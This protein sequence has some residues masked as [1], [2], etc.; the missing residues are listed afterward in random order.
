MFIAWLAGTPI[1]VCHS[2]NSKSQYEEQSGRHK[3]VAVYRAIMRKLLWTFS[4]FRC[5]CSAV[6]MDYLYQNKW[7]SDPHS[8]VVYNGIDLTQ[9]SP[10]NVDSVTSSAREKTLI[11]VGRFELQKNPHFIVKVM[12]ALCDIDSEYTLDWI[13]TG[14]MEAEIRAEIRQLGLEKNIKLL[15]KR[16]DVPDLLKQASGFLLPSLFE[17]L[18]IALIEAQAAGLTCVVSD[19]I[20]PEVDMGKCHF[21]PLNASPEDWAKEIIALRNASDSID[22]EKLKQFDSA[23][24]V[25]KMEEIYSA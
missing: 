9:F 3:T 17:G 22:S 2:H 10:N 5:G 1:R 20:S 12:R 8:R 19:Q 15:G 18:P 11:T 16:K 21:V 13:G 7:K 25:R 23:F 24:M 4:T 14:S 6:A